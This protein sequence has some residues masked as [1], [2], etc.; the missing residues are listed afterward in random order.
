MSKLSES[1]RRA[2]KSLT[3]DIEV[4][5]P[6]GIRSVRTLLDSG[7]QAN[8]IS[9]LLIAE[10]KV[11]P[12]DSGVSVRTVGGQSIRVYGRHRLETS[13]TD[14]RDACKKQAIEYI[15]TDIQTHGAILG[16]P[17]LWETNPDIDWNKGTWRFREDGESPVVRVP[18]KELLADIEPENLGV[19]LVRPVKDDLPGVGGETLANLE[20]VELDPRFRKYERV[21]GEPSE[22]PFGTDTKTR[23]TIPVLEGE[24]V[25]WGPIYPLSANE[26]RAL[27]EYLDDAL[28]K[29]WI[30][31]SESPAGAPILFVPKHDGSLR[32]CADFRGLNKVTKKNRYPLPLIPE[33]LDRLSG[34]KIFSKMDL[35][36]AYHRIRVAQEDRWKTAF[37]TRYGHFE[38]LVMPFGLTNAPASFQAYINEAL[39]GLLDHICIA[40]MDDILI[41]SQ[42][43]EEHE[44]HMLLVLERLEKYSLYAK[45]SK[46]K[47]FQSEVDFL[48]YRVGVDGVSMDP[49][50]VQAI[51]E[52]PVPK[53]FRDIQ[54]F[55]GFANFYRGFIYRYSHVVAPITDLLIGMKAGKKTGPFEWTDS[56]DK[57]F[58]TLKAC[59]SPDTVLAHFDPEKGSRVE[60]DASGE[61]IGG[62]LTQ[63]CETQGGRTLWKPVA[64]F[65]RKLTPA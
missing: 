47:F 38:Y 45:L 39:R 33:I 40:Y 52:W 58:R 65:S 36:D 7:A 26:L 32:L 25:P 1:E 34:A 23:H 48:G 21:F 35:R 28:R 53:S 3:L 54:V 57:A 16:Y 56:A 13:I 27:R 30:Q 15:A 22:D 9:Q 18:L 62:V 51:Q 14:W 63:A 61:A 8:F 6:T 60:V 37:R 64:F 44:K 43:E 24:R 10:M 29:G 4:E 11:D 17:W 46:C 19:I 12:F 5:G 49:S 42:D 41:F 31:P 2:Q 55:L 20:E 59:F 50:R